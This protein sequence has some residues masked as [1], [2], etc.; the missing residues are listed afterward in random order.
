MPKLFR[1]LQATL[2]RAAKPSIFFSALLLSGCADHYT[3]AIN[4]QPV[5]DPTGRLFNGRL[6]DPN[7]QGCVNIAMQ[8]QN[9]QNAELLT[10]LACGDSEVQT[11]ENIDRLAALRFLELSNNR[12]HDLSPL[13]RLRSLGGLD[14]S[15]NV[16]TDISPLLNMPNLASVNL[17]G[18][19]EIPCQQLDA[20]GE[21]LGNNLTRPASCRNPALGR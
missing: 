3:V 7:L 20:L 8:N 5:F 17:T 13:Q 6:T 4:N 12:L 14:L 15:N 16:I 10:V 2:W 11:L 21:R 9:I 18:N 1:R 19:L